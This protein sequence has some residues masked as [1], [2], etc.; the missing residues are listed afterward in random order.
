MPIKLPP[1]G[2]W[3]YAR[4]DDEVSRGRLSSLR[5]LLMS[6]LQQQYGREPIKIFQDVA[7]IPPGAAWQEEI[8]NALNRAT[9]LIPII[10]PAFIESE[11]CCEEVRL[12]LDRERELNAAHPE[13]AGRRR[14]FPILYVEIDD[15]E[16]VDAE[17]LAELRKIQW[18]DF[19]SLKFKA[20][21]EEPVQVA[22]AALA[23]GMSKML[24]V[25]VQP[26][27]TPEELAAQEEQA[28][29]DLVRETELLESRANTEAERARAA[30]VQGDEAA[31]RAKAGA[32]GHGK[33]EA[34][35][36]EFTYVYYGQVNNNLANGFGVKTWSDGE[37]DRGEF[38]GG[39]LTGH[40]VI[41]Y[42]SGSKAEGEVKLNAMDGYGTY[43][44]AKSDAKTLGR[45][46]HSVVDG[47]Y[48]T[49]FSTGSIFRGS[50]NGMGIMFG[51]G[52]EVA[53]S[54]IYDEGKLVRTIAYRTT[55]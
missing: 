16:P 33:L 45:Y 47:P 18:V 6:E 37:I 29:L 38:V 15:I 3:S 28:L 13:L 35:V 31:E 36:G 5:S 19:T 50:G 7:A 24:Q 17:I 54:G 21:H 4:Q 14:I 20:A 23:R 41:S 42:N 27:P 40:G 9:F 30:A 55:Q 8:S 46:V 48:V 49:H 34:T 12:F 10:T 52:G 53:S 43:H 44:D 25:R 2:F 26:A 11:F 51:A 39:N 22:L 32:S 1:I